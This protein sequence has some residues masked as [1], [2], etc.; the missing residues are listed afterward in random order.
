[1]GRERDAE[2]RGLKE[3]ADETKELRKKLKKSLADLRGAKKKVCMEQE[4]WTIL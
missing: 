4:I 3:S 2:Q 1:M